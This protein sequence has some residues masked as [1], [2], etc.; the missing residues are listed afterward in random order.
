M[1]AV[2]DEQLIEWVAKGDSSCLGTL[3]E[4]HHRSVYQF[5]LQMTRNRANAEDVAQEVF[6]KVLRKAH[7]YRHEG[8]FKAWMFNI[9]RNA[10]FDYLRKN[11]SQPDS[12]PQDDFADSLMVDH[13]TAEH[14]ASGMQD[15]GTLQ[16][17]L[18]TLPAQYQ[19]I[20]WLARFEFPTFVELG[21]ALGCKTGTARV[22]M[23]RAM[24]QLNLAYTELNGAP[25][26]A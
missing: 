12:L 26:D 21:A 17:A 23:H 9:A 11:K 5:C 25:F 6:M 7:T 19:E 13:R 18:A 3:F 2:S 8:T 22:R 4:R 15:I 1:Q 20:I 10:T 24:Q 16:R 14:A